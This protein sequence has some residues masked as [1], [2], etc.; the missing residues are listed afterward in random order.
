MKNQKLPRLSIILENKNTKAKKVIETK[1]RPS[2]GTFSSYC[3]PIAEKEE[4]KEVENPYISHQKLSSS[5]LNDSNIKS[6]PHKI[7]NFNRLPTNSEINFEMVPYENNEEEYK[8]PS[9][10]AEIIF[11]QKQEII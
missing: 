3:I 1:K 4:E 10:E 7:I 2:L 11:P 5:N 6:Q 9:K 8:S